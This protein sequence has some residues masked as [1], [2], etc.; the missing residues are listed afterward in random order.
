MSVYCGCVFFVLFSWDE[1]L[2]QVSAEAPYLWV[3]LVV[4]IDSQELLFHGTLVKNNSPWRKSKCIRSAENFLNTLFLDNT[5]TT[6]VHAQTRAPMSVSQPEFIL[7]SLLQIQF[8][9]EAVILFCFSL[10]LSC[11]PRPVV[12]G[13]GEQIGLEKIFMFC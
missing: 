7:P 6:Q 12:S 8:M 1:G 4:H 5:G 10:L 13:E 3:S 11:F 9:I 2:G